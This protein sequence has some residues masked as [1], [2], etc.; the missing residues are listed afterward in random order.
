MPLPT[1]R[2]GESRDDFVSRFMSNEQ[3]KRD[4]PEQEQRLA[5]AFSTWRKHRGGTKPK[6][7]NKIQLNFRVPIEVLENPVEEGKEPEFL[8]Q[9][10][11]I[12]S[13]VTDNN[14]KFIGEELLSAANS[15]NNVPLLK[16][17]DN[18]VDSIVGRVIHSEFNTADENIL[19][20]ARINSTEA[21]KHIKQLIKSGDL[22]T[23]SIGANVETLEEEDDMFI[24]RGITFKELS[25]VAVPADEGAKFT[26]TGNNFQ[27]ALRE[28]YK[29]LEK[30][31]IHG[32]EQ[33]PAG[34]DISKE[35]TDIVEKILEKET[36]QSQIDVVE[37]NINKKEKD[38][39]EKQI[40]KESENSES[41]LADQFKAQS[42][43]L[44]QVLQKL[45]D[46]G[47]DFTDFKRESTERFESLKEAD[48]DEE[49][50]EAP[51]E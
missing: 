37:D 19:F 22:N 32:V 20:K 12:N 47:K 31:A 8:I 41:K 6:E 34:T 3:A 42:E 14:H 51:A 2:T 28:A 26:F 13:S 24:P 18:M 21:G 44:S 7:M 38:M 45:D 10:I 25:L 11:A 36:S 43:L 4:F 23:V 40:Q 50:E 9:G 27:L 15:L 49:P 29:G 35:G 46:Q 33:T 48:A 17:H 30:E 16:D 5:V 1:P 39:E